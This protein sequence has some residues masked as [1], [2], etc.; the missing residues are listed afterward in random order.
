MKINENNDDNKQLQWNI[1]SSNMN[2]YRNAPS[3]IIIDNKLFIFGGRY[4]DDSEILNLNNMNN[5]N[6]KFENGPQL[7]Y[8]SWFSG[9][10][11]CQYNHHIIIAGGCQ[12][13]THKLIQIMDINKQQFELFTPSMNNEH[14]ITPLIITSPDPL[15]GLIKGHKLMIVMGNY[16]DNHNDWGT[17]EYC[18]TRLKNGK[19]ITIDKIQNILNINDESKKKIVCISRIMHVEI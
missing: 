8:V 14:I 9:I 19:W 2:T 12:E 15:N 11:Y 17:I 10:H 18:D 6:I 1:L 13:N 4:N 3:S 16:R 7:K 5:D